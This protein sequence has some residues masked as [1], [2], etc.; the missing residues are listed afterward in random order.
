MKLDHVIFTCTL[1]TLLIVTIPFLFEL[2]LVFAII[3]LILLMVING[4]IPLMTKYLQ[5][6]KKKV[7][8]KKAKI[9]IEACSAGSILLVPIITIYFLR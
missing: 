6:T 4:F 5:L 1:R 8:E 2:R 3:G 9:I 7:K